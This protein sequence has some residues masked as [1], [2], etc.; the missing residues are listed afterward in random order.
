M[1][2]SSTPRSPTPRT[3]DDWLAHLKTLDLPRDADELRRVLALERPGAGVAI[4][5]VARRAAEHSLHAFAPE[6][7]AA[8]TR[9][10][11]DAKRD[12]GCRGKN[13]IARCLHDLDVWEEAVFAAGATL[14]QLE[15]PL[16]EITGKQDDMAAELRGICALA[17]AR[18]L[19]P[20]ALDVIAELLVD[21]W[22]VTRIAAA[23]ALGACG[24]Y[25]A[26][27]LLRYKLLAVDDEPEVL[28]AC[29]DS[30][31]ELSR[32]ASPFLIKLLSNHDDRAEAAALALGGARIS[33]ARDA[34]IEWCTACS[35]D[36]R[37]RAG[38]VVLAL[39]R[40]DV[41]NAFLAEAIAKRAKAD[42]LAA[43]RAL[44]TFN[45]HEPTREL[46]ATAIASVK[47]T[48]V[49]RELGKLIADQNS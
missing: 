7:A 11:A 42:A 36:R 10:V 24:R 2:R 18:F 20:D 9:L 45:D 32:D 39:L 15:G 12:P 13:A 14:V 21:E 41:A 44:A 46:L 27:A 8:F 29:C 22:A 26:T 1:A 47:D 43:A 6:L 3:I 34:L 37:H 40:D 28:A 48:A 17:Y 16:S 33:D 5:A 35:P 49:R 23:R 19:R 30:L 38:Y 4:A 31:L 25:D